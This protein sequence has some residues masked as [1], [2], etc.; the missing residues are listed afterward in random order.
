MAG[1]SKLNE[2]N[3]PPPPPPPPPPRIIREGRQPTKRASIESTNKESRG[4]REFIP[5]YPNITEIEVPDERTQH[6]NTLRTQREQNPYDMKAKNQS[7]N[8]IAFIV[9]VGLAAI[10]YI[11]FEL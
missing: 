7:R 5:G 11:I 2:R 4:R 8:I 9:L 1:V 10:T 3:N 6:I